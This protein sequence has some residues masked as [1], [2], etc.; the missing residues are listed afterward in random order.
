MTDKTWSDLD[1]EKGIFS[2]SGLDIDLMVSKGGT[3]EEICREGKDCDV[4]MVLFT[5]M[6]RQQLDIFTRCRAL[7]RMGIGT[8]SVDLDFAGRKS[9]QVANVPDYCQEEVADH[10]L[11]LFLELTRKVGMLDREVRK[12]RWEMS[13]ADPVPRLRN[14]T[15]ALWGCG[16][17]GRLTGRRAAA[18]GMKLTGY[19]P[20]LPAETFEAH[21]IARHTDLDSFLAGADVVSLHAPLTPATEN[22][23]NEKT[24]GRMKPSAYLLNSSRGKLIDEDALYAAL[25]NGSIA[26]AGLDVLREEPPGGVHRFCEFENCVITPHAAWNSI[27]AIPELRVKAAEE[28]VRFLKTGRVKNLVNKDALAHHETQAVH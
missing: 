5:P 4:L 25:K 12:G 14:L 16:G 13:V 1:I 17:I 11:A 7:V 24:L 19:D 27:D 20:F 8:N 10:T 26:G 9:I 3:P 23:V 15:F 22:M 18:F 2:S 28:A 6:G 21:G